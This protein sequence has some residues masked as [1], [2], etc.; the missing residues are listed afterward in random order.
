MRSIDIHLTAISQEVIHRL[1]TITR[2]SL[3]ITYLKCHSNLPGANEVTH[4]QGLNPVNFLLGRQ[5]GRRAECEKQSLHSAWGKD[6]IT[7]RLWGDTARAEVSSGY[8]SDVT[9]VVICLR[10]LASWLL[11]QQLTKANNKEKNYAPNHRCFVRGIHWWPVDS[12][13]GHWLIVQEVEYDFWLRFCI[14]CRLLKIMG[15]NL[16]MQNWR[17]LD[18]WDKI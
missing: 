12:I 1:I 9:G 16:E 18:I 13:V 14:C 15:G 11:V 4:W 6:S 7:R 3:K 2:I 17:N 10:S 5:A 8:Y